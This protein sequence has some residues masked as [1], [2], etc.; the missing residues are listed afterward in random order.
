MMQGF[1]EAAALD[2]ILRHIDRKTL[3]AFGKQ[4]EALVREALALDLAYMRQN[5]VLTPEGSGGDAF[6][7]DDEAFEAIVEGLAEKH[8]L[9]DAKTAKVGLL[10]DA[11]MDAMESYMEQA[12][13]LQWE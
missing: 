7:D 5:G 2:S 10:V 9:D 12:G 3:S 1:D 8:G 4:G 11:Y 13:L 6:Y